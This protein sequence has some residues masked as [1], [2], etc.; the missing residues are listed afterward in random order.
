V[1][2]LIPVKLT[3]NKIKQESDILNKI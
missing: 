3:L 1:L 2:D